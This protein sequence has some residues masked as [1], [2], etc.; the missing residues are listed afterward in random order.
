MF[1]VYIFKSFYLGH[2]TFGMRKVFKRRIFIK[3]INRSYKIIELIHK[4]I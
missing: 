3:K 4:K 2:A 1:Y